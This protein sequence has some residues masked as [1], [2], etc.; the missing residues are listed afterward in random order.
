MIILQDGLPEE[1]AFDDA[2]SCCEWRAGG[3]IPV[4]ETPAT[5]WPDLSEDEQV[6][7]ESGLHLWLEGTEGSAQQRLKIASWRFVASKS[8]HHGCEAGL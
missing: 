1:D 5:G 3:E 2:A 7:F 6:E 8:V 4:L